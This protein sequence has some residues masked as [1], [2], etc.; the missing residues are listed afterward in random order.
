MHA[1]TAARGRTRDLWPRR[2][3][4]LTCAYPRSRYRARTSARRCRAR[5]APRPVGRGGPPEYGRAVTATG[6]QKAPSATPLS[7]IG[8]LLGESTEAAAAQREAPGLSPRRREKKAVALRFL[9]ARPSK[10]YHDRGSRL[11]DSSPDILS[12]RRGRRPFSE[13]KKDW[14]KEKNLPLS[15]KAVRH[16][17]RSRPCGGKI[18]PRR[19]RHYGRRTGGRW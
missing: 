17:R 15:R 7:H 18:L 6:G 14:P 13:R 4:T 19:R 2:G 11:N 3:P 1:T 16:R 8:H 12:A 9:F 10:N 5:Q